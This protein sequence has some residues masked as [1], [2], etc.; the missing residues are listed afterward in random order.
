MKQKVSILLL[1]T[2]L[3][4]TIVILGECRRTPLPES[5]V[6]AITYTATQGVGLQTPTETPS[7]PA[8][9]ATSVVGAPPTE[10]PSPLPTVPTLPETQ[11]PYPEPSTQTEYPTSEVTPGL[12]YPGPVSTNTQFVSPSPQASPSPEINTPTLTSTIIPAYPGASPN[13]TSEVL[14]P[15]PGPDY[16]ATSPAYPEPLSTS[17]SPA[18]PGPATSTPL[19][20]STPAISSTP[21]ITPTV[22]IYPT[23]IS[24]QGIGTPVAT[25]TEMPPRQP[26][27]PPPPGSSVTIWHSWGSTET[28]TLQSIIQSFQRLYPNVTFSLQYI[29]QDDLFNSYRE[30]VY[31]GQGPSLLFGPSS[32]GPALFDD[33]LVSNLKPF[34]PANY[35]VNINPAAMASGKYEN[36]L[37]SLPLSQHG[38]LMFRNIVLFTEPPANLAEMT[39]MALEITHG[40]VVGSYLERGSYFSSPAINGLGGRLMD[41][42][43]YPT[44]NDQYGL[45][46]FNLLEAYDEAG[47]VTFNTN[48]DLEKFKQNRVGIII[49][50]SWNITTLAQ[51]IG[52]ENLA[53]DPWPAYSTGHLS[54]WV[55]TDSVFLN[56]NTTGNNR[57][58]ALSFMGYLLD[59]NV[60]MHLAEVGHIPSVNTTQPRDPLI[61]QAMIAFLNGTPYP[62]TVDSNVLSIYRTELD[63]AIRDVFELGIDPEAALQTAEDNINQAME[64]QNHQP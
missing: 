64:A 29:P 52:M 44:F 56:S 1:I 63:K 34:V 51:A 4:S 37:I 28:A 21:G 62:I 14:L 45:E 48:Y 16:T 41:E 30:A 25:P 19:A 43:G 22:T 36:S 17:T 53:I 23:A 46:W 57:F 2:L 20:T 55:E 42:N 24:T 39:S 47:A 35:L 31:Q 11:I 15:Y 27:S 6:N 26:L 10:L 54:G 33:L 18:Y 38:L 40:G 3:L 58:A 50:G 7:Q 32:W 61:K 8:S 9:Q 49:D 60:Q 59:P 12:G 5:P 13:P